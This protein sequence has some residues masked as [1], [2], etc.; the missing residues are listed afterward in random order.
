MYDVIAIT[1]FRNDPRISA[2]NQILQTL[3]NR[4]VT[5][6][7][8]PHWCLD[9]HGLVRCFLDCV[10]LPSTL[11]AHVSA[12]HLMLD[13]IQVAKLSPDL[14]QYRLPLEKKFESDNVDGEALATMTEA[15]LLK[16]CDFIVGGAVSRK[17]LEKRDEIFSELM[18]VKQTC[19]MQHATM[20]HF[21]E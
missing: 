1:L 14:E 16:I 20:R 21:E 18:R 10:M 13:V 4:A 15:D 8:T 7:K 9:A 3:E 5:L 17:V 12:F 2:F 11:M 19:E 6:P